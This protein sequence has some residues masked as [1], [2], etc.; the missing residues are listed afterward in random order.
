MFQLEQKVFILGAKSAGVVKKIDGV[1]KRY[2]V[3]YFTKSNPNKRITSWFNADQL[4]PFES[5]N[6]NNQYH[7]V[8][9]LHQKFGSPYAETPKILSG[10]GESVNKDYSSI[11]ESISKEMKKRSAVGQGGRVLAR[12]SWMLEE[13]AEFLAAETI[14]DQ[15]DALTDLNYFDTGTFVEIGIKPDDLFDIVHNSNV[16]KLWSDGKPRF[17]EQGKWIKPPNWE[18]DHAPEPKLRAEITRQIKVS[19]RR[20]SR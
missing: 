11:L 17:N 5:K 6:K 1:E 18:K 10:A 4:K 19:Q 20:K 16:G 7:K 3:T 13:L 12:S 14:E 8:K 15:A 2:K 9:Y